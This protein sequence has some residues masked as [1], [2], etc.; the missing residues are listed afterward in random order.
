MKKSFQTSFGSTIPVI[1]GYKEAHPKIRISDILTP[2]TQMVPEK[3]MG[4]DGF[5]KDVYEYAL[6]I[7]FLENHGIKTSWNKGLDLGGAE[8]T[9]SRLLRGEGKL[10]T[11]VT[12]DISDAS[13]NL[14][15][16]SFL[17]HYFRFR[18][19]CA[20]SRFSPKLK[21]FLLGD[22]LW[23]GHR[24]TPLFNHWG[25]WPPLSSKFWNLTLKRVPS[26]DR[27]IAGDV[28]D[29]DEKFDLITSFFCLDYF[30][31]EKIFAKISGLLAEGG[32]F[33]MAVN[34]WWYSVSA[35]G[36]VGDFPY[37]CQRLTREDFLRY[38]HEFHPDEAEDAI[39]RYDYYHQ[40][41]IHPTLNDYAEI[42]DR[43]DMTTLASAQLAP[44][45][46]VHH[47]SA[48]TPAQMNR[49]EDSRL[50]DV[51]ADIRRFRPDIGL[52]DLQ[53]AHVMLVFQKRTK[54]SG[55]LGTYLQ[56]E[57]LKEKQRGY[58]T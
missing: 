21:S 43:Y 29:L 28:Y 38:F 47:R 50:R 41:A 58:T 9:M 15:T 23:R 34:Y 57:E 26:I 45:R 53:T 16:A 7:D 24:L 39:Q 4:I 42:A 52:L 35:A 37:C 20:F 3:R 55:S 33:F 51:L 11:A 56:S 8:G 30:N 31:I 32:T 18:V 48:V 46:D 2:Y 5:I 14:S 17:K 54:Q 49:F 19:A 6:M 40:S 22:G 25:Y 44:P 12:V 27:Y 10:K 13:H 36:I 1:P